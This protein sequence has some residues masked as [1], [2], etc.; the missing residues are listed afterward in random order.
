M[1]RKGGSIV[2]G[3]LPDKLAI[4]CVHVTLPVRIF[5]DTG[6]QNGLA[7]TADIVLCSISLL[8]FPVSAVGALER[9]VFEFSFEMSLVS[10]SLC[11]CAASAPFGQLYRLHAVFSLT[12]ATLANGDVISFNRNFSEVFIVSS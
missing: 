11:F 2:A 1:L 7:S 12:S 8:L 6:F 4:R 10:T 5:L 9:L 3:L